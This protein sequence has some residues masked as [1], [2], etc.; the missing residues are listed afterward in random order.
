M[1]PSN[2]AKLDLSLCMKTEITS[3]CRRINTEIEK[4]KMKYLYRF[5][6]LHGKTC[7]AWLIQRQPRRLAP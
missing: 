3:W 2:D 4:S 7:V 5:G 1:L 6:Y